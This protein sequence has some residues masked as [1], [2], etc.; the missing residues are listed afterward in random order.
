MYR[1]RVQ[2]RKTISLLNN[3]PT[4][5]SLAESL[6]LSFD[7]RMALIATLISLM[8]SMIKG[9]L[10]HQS[11]KLLY[12]KCLKLS[13]SYQA[14]TEVHEGVCRNHQETQALAFKLIS[15]EYYWSTMKK[16]ASNYVKK[17]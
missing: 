15:C 10:F 2:S 14:L 8:Y 12:L 13:K 7:N 3:F 4:N 17:M 1:E 6:S 9:V 5:M 16:D 11:L